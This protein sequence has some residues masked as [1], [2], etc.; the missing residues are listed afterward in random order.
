[1]L[2][3]FYLICVFPNSCNYL[4]IVTSLKHTSLSALFSDFRF[5]YLE[6]AEVFFF[7]VKHFIVDTFNMWILKYKMHTNHFYLCFSAHSKW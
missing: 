6:I 7:N 5:S 4:H 3:P 1:M 2:N